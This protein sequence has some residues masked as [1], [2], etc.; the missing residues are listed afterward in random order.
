MVDIARKTKGITPLMHATAAQLVAGC[1]EKDDVCEASTL[2]AFVR[3]NIR[4][5]GDIRNV[6]TIKFPDQTLNL[7]YGDCDD[8]ALLL[9]ALAEAIN[10]ST[11]FCAVGLNG[12]TYSHVLPQILIRGRGWT[13]AEVI[14]IDDAGTRAPFG[15]FPPD[16]TCLMVAHV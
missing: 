8:K 9:A 1:P 3:D 11:R 7:G 6:E 16:A 13:S 12:E 10:F 14:P 15:W 5:V 4:Y 2:H